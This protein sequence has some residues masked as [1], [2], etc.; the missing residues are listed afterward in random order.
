MVG[1]GLN[2]VLSYNLYTPTQLTSPVHDIKILSSVCT[3]PAMN[4]EKK[5]PAP[6]APLPTASV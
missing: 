6:P 5:N 4:V 3:H 1:V 2:A